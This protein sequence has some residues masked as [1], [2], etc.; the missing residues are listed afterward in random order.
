MSRSV[1]WTSGSGSVSFAAAV[2][3]PRYNREHPWA[4]RLMLS[5]PDPGPQQQKGSDSSG[6]PISG[7]FE[8]PWG[9]SWSRSL[10]GTG[11]AIPCTH[12]HS[13]A[14]ESRPNPTAHLAGAGEGK[15]MI[16]RHNGRH[17]EVS[18]VKV[19]AARGATVGVIAGAAALG[20]AGSASAAPDS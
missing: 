16:R 5:D 14:D 1:L 6:E 19:L 17:R 8:L 9:E 10:E 18:R 15:H 11:R 13:F 3:S 12:S 20:F 2:V 4:M 7:S